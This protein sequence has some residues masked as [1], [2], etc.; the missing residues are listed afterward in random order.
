MNIVI[1]GT[2]NVAHFFAKGIMA[3]GSHRLGGVFART[4]AAA[5]KFAR[6]YATSVISS[7]SEIPANVDLVLLCVPD[8]AIAQLDFTCDCIV[9]HCSGTATLDVLKNYSSKSACL[10][11]I[12]S[13]TEEMEFLMVPIVITAHKECADD[14]Y[15]FCKS[16]SFEV[17]RFN[18]EQKAQAH[19]V[20]TIGNNFSNFLFAQIADYCHNNNVPPQLFFKLFRQPV[21]YFSDGTNEEHQT[22]PA[23]RNDEATINAHEAL[24]Q[25]QPSLKSLYQNF[26]ALIKAKSLLS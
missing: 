14:V 7:L 1:V 19:V 15:E 4:K 16:F 21:H 25:S 5:V 23:M 2:G 18:E 6:E 12:Y 3:S 20:A 26:T 22:G 24:L 8:S 11:P 10:W 17:F 9:A 13:I